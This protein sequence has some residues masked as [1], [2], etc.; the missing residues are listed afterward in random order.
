MIAKV[1]LGQELWWPF[2]FSPTSHHSPLLPHTDI[3][4]GAGTTGFMGH[5]NKRHC[6]YVHPSCSNS[7]SCHKQHYLT[8]MPLEKR[9]LQFL[10]NLHYTQMYLKQS[11]SNRLCHLWTLL[12]KKNAVLIF[13]WVYTISYMWKTHRASTLHS[14]YYRGIWCLHLH[15]CAEDT[16]SRSFQNVGTYTVF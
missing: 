14:Q 8:Q 2:H 15:F 16:G 6:M 12:K 1:A 9:L 3:S 7:H 10:M 5:S 11:P 4:P 13:H